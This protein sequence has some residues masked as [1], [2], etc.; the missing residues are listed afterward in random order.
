MRSTGQHQFAG[1]LRVVK[2]VCK[3]S[4]LSP[5]GVGCNGSRWRRASE[6]RGPAV[7]GRAEGGG[8][9]PE[10]L[11]VRERELAVAGVGVGVA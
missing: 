4:N 6:G 9:R 10:A 1:K 11:S 5:K 8:D 2:A 3:L 7:V